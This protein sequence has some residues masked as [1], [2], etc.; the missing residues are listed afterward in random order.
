MCDAEQKVEAADGDNVTISFKSPDLDGADQVMITL[1]GEN[2]K[3]VIA[4]YCRCAHCGDCD[5]VETPRVFL[6][7]EEGTLILLR[8][9]SR[10]SGLYEAI[11]IG[12]KVSRIKATL[13]VNSEYAITIYLYYEKNH[14]NGVH[15]VNINRNLQE[16]QKSCPFIK[17]AKVG[18]VSNVLRW[19]LVK[20]HLIY[21]LIIL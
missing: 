3:T 14:V 9:R 2:H 18:L 11:I 6:R 17:V 21:G 1:T 4:R 15:K 10:D 7:V 13:V 8:V 20:G 5:V 16:V 19:Y 12:K